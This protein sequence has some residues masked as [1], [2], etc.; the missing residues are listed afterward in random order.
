MN[1]D[2]LPERLRKRIVVDDSTGCWRWTAG[3]AGK[4][5][6]YFHWEGRMSYAHRIT[7]HLLV[8][9]SMP[10]S[11]GGHKQC[12]DHVADLCAHKDCVNP[13]HLE[14]VTWSENLLRHYKAHPKPRRAAA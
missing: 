6:G 13:A 2:Q 7:Y 14:L 5:Y 9:Q 4:G 3:K 8:D 12:I 11:G 10:V 1:V